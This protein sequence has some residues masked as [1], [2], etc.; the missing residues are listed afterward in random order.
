MA[1]YTVAREC[2]RG[3][4]SALCSC[5]KH[6]PDLDKEGWADAAPEHYNRDKNVE[7][8]WGGCTEDIGAGYR[9]TKPFIDSSWLPSWPPY[10]RMAPSPAL[11]PWPTAWPSPDHALS[12]DDRTEV[13]EHLANL[14]VS[15]QGRQV[16]SA[17]GSYSYRMTR[18]NVGSLYS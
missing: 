1:M 8:H 7:M 11:E 9:L 2:A 13:A 5:A 18:C 10:A 4:L 14:H 3:E 12:D 17:R 15:E 16:S 6:P